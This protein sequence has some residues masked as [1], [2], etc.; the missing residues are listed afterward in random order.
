MNK[1]RFFAEYDRL[2]MVHTETC[3]DDKDCALGDELD[4]LIERYRVEDLDDEV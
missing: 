2:V 4:R 3:G 1:R